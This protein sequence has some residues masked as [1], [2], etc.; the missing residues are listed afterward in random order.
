MLHS[1]GYWR[2]DMTAFPEAPKFTADRALMRTDPKKFQEVLAD[3]RKKAEAYDEQFAIYDAEA[4]DAVDRFRKENGLD[5]EGNARGL[6][7][8]RLI[9]ALRDRYH[10]R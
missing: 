6:V 10:A 3:Y 1:I 5:Y 2:K 8:E 4:M 9:R 7:D